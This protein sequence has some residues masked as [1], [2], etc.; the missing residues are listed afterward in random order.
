MLNFSF[1]RSPRP[2][3]VL[4]AALLGAGLLTPGASAQTGG[5]LPLV[6]VGQKWPQAQET[7]VIRVT[8]QDAARSVG[9]EVYSPT[10]N[11][12][13]YADGRRGAGYFGDERY[14][15]QDQM[16]TTFTLVG[17]AGTVV[18][19]RFGMNREHTWESLYAGP[20]PA[21]TYTL[22]VTTRG[23]GKNSFALRTAAPFA[24]ETSDFSVNARDTE[25]TPLLA[26]R[27]L[28]TP[29]WI[30]KTLSLQN[31][32]LD[33]PREA[34]TWAVQP[35]GARVNLT[36]SDNGKT[37]ADKFPITAALV[38]EWQV[39]IRV[40]PTT[41]Q[42]SNAIRYSFRMNDAPFPARVGG[43]TPPADLKLLNQLLVEVVD[44]QG[45]PVPGAT[46]AVIGDGSVKPVLPPG[47]QAVSSALVQGTGNIIS[48]T[49]VRYQPGY[50]KVRFVARQAEGQLVVEAVAVY[51]TQR[52]AMPNVPFE[53]AGRTFTTPATVPLTPGDYA[54][55]PTDV[56]GSTF[57]QPAPGRVPDGGTGRVV[58]EYR[59]LTEITLS[60]TPD[61]LN[62]CDPAQLVAV[63]KTDFPYR[64]PARVR[65][66]LPSGWSSDYPLELSGEFGGGQR[67]NLKV[68]VRICRS[69][70]AEAI[71]DPIDLRTTGPAQVR[72]PG[73][74]NVTR[75][76]QG[77]GR[78]SLAKSVELA[79]AGTQGYVVTLVLTVDSTLENVRLIDMLPQGSVTPATRGT[80]QTLEGPSLATLNPRVEG[81]SIVLTRVIPGRYV[82]RY[83]LFTDL[84]A[85]RVVT[86][87]DLSW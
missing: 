68:P 9:L 39:F 5:V 29:D 4:S 48:P 43:F 18:E 70:T 8:A 87:P 51:G 86:P 35:G 61:V 14:N 34:E 7:Y 40:L 19:R 65:L 85:D 82:L 77:G 41:K 56:P 23:D 57:T 1:P 84:P 69:D 58:I 79:P 17:P 67:L 30:G 3:L 32:D 46:Y 55:K 49:E 36:P 20:L 71:L 10:F 45:R 27:L 33:G 47:W 12:A 38:G 44:P 80:I 25:Q 13:D 37:A 21:G 31:Y 60:T 81:D 22:K 66:N 24:L 15:Q 73:G 62:A 74:A 11:L 63:A 16:E 26:A 2:A 59:P 53:V 52:I 78:A 50:N 64:L 28:I 42:Y 6:S 72:N 83:T 76:V 54:V 75:N